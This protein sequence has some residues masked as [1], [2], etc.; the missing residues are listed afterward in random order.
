MGRQLSSGDGAFRHGAVGCGVRSAGSGAGAG[1]RSS[2]VG[3]GRSSP[4]RVALSSDA[5][6]AESGVGRALMRRGVTA[7]AFA[8]GHRGLAGRFRGGR[9]FF[10]FR[11][12]F[13]ILGLDFHVTRILFFIWLGFCMVVVAQWW[14]FSIWT[15]GWT[16]PYAS[17]GRFSG[18]L[19]S[20]GLVVAGNVGGQGGGWRFGRG[21]GAGWQGKRRRFLRLRRTGVRPQVT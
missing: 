6:P 2:S 18:L 15:A 3:A 10:G 19:M 20:G 14:D 4:G 13:C 17:C 11:V 1:A 8:G 21:G 16:T 5:E 9:M 7:K 12:W